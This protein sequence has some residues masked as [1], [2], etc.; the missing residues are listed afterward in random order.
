MLQTPKCP[1]SMSVTGAGG[2]GPGDQM[3]DPG[4]SGC[5]YPVS[6]AWTFCFAL[7]RPQLVHELLL[8]IAKSQFW[9]AGKFTNS[10]TWVLA[11]WRSMSLSYQGSGIGDSAATAV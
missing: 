11:P 5:R 7:G 6:L 3:V 2:S 1:R 10:D 8:L 9:I 4:H